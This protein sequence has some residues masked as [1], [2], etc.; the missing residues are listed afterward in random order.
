MGRTGTWDGT[1]TG[2]AHYGGDGVNSIEPHSA[3]PM[4]HSSEHGNECLCV[5]KT[6]ETVPDRRLVAF[7]E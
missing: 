3:G 4:A 2:L 1:A 5:V 6:R 7:Q